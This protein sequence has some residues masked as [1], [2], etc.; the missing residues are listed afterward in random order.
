M[1]KLQRYIHLFLGFKILIVDL[2]Y[3]NRLLF[4][5]VVDN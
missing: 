4:F 3:I 1:N 5:V 2:L